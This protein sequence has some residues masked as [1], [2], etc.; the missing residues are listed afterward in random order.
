[1]GEFH[2][3]WNDFGFICDGLSNVGGYKRNA[4]FSWSCLLQT[5][6]YLSINE[7]LSVCRQFWENY[8]VTICGSAWR[9]DVVSQCLEFGLIPPPPPPQSYFYI[10]DPSLMT[11]F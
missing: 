4:W 6:C 7:K 10:N 1:M 8:G 5:Y 11:T 3:D 9:K 2:L